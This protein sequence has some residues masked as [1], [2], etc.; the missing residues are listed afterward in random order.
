[1]R[2]GT[3][4]TWQLPSAHHHHHETMA[5]NHPQYQFIIS[6]KER[7]KPV[8]HVWV[9]HRWLFNDTVTNWEYSLGRLEQR[10]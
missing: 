3:A 10:Y 2:N 5:L 1:V 9:S 4:D 8:T 7:V 6:I